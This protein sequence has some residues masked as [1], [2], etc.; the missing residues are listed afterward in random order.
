[1]AE[2]YSA[3]HQTQMNDLG[4]E[5]DDAMIKL[6]EINQTKKS[7]IKIPT[8]KILTFSGEYQKFYQVLPL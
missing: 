3:T 1:M 5:Y 4:N 8:I 6:G 2:E 7:E